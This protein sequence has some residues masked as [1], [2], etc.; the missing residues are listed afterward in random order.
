MLSCERAVAHRTTDG[1]HNTSQEP[2]T[3]TAVGLGAP[4]C[5][6]DNKQIRHPTRQARTPTAVGLG[7]PDCSQDNKQIR[8]PTH[9]GVK[10]RRGCTALTVG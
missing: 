7:A 9:R 8:H 6:Q 1:P 3:T 2:E 5:S 10:S 4:D